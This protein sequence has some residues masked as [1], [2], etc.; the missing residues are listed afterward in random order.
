MADADVFISYSREDQPTARLYAEA[1]TREGF[2]VWWDQAL[3]SGEAFDQVIEDAIKSAK[4]VVV[5]W[6]ESSCSSR[7]VRAEAT[8]AERTGGLAPVRIGPCQLPIMF[9]LTHTNDLSHWKG[10]VADGAWRRLVADL[11]ALVAKAAVEP[12]VPAAVTM[13]RGAPFILPDKPSIAVLPLNDLS[14]EDHDHFAE[15]IVEEISTA[16]S[17]FQTLF[18]IAG[19]SSLTY[20]DPNRDPAKVCRE[21]GVRYLLD[22]SIRRAKDRVRI[23]VRLIDGIEGVQVWADRFDDSLDDIF[24]LQERVAHAVAARIDSSIDT[25]E[26]ARSRSQPAVSSGAYELYWRANAVFRR[27]DPASLREAIALTEQVLSL[28][29]ENAWAASLA[30]FCYATLFANGVA[31]DPFAIRTKALELYEKALINGGDDARVLG[32][33]SAALVCAAG[34]PEIAQ[35]LTVRALQINPGSAT[36][37]F[38]GAWNDI[39]LGNP[40]QGLE[41]FETALRLNPMSIVR[42]MTV[43]GMG[44]CRLF[45]G[46]FSEAA[47]ILLEASPQLPHFPATWAGLTAALAHAGRLSEARKAREGLRRLN[48]SRGPLALMRAPQQTEIL[49]QGIEM[50]DAGPSD[51][52]A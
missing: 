28:D 33:C 6:S 5:L 37:L 46:R 8:L 32:Y 14:G 2:N 10:N 50:A 39:I 11:R 3:R 21:L 7:W 35:R 16:L 42:P 34:D 4:A 1:L 36:N 27:M 24:D 20:R 29:P 44:L 31:E 52:S 12:E 45:Q 19:A 47:D 48:D 40:D 43:T 41:R 26:V 13:A 30:A 18:V 25:A 51:R 22:G 23:S 49:N 17:R 15:G 38:W 9:E